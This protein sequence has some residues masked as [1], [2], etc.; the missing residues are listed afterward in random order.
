MQRKYYFKCTDC[1]AEFHDADFMYLCP[2]CAAKNQPGQP[3]RG[4]LKTLYDFEE[5]K[6]RFQ[7]DHSFFTSQQ[8]LPLLPIE[9][10]ESLGH[11]AVGNTP[12]I[13]VNEL[14]GK[15]LPFNLALKDDSRN[16]T[17]SFKDRASVLVSAYAKEHG[18]DTII[19]AST[20][21][22]GSSL[23]GI[24]ASQKQKAIICVP[25]A[26][27]KAKLTQILMYGAQI[28]PVA[29]TYDDAF[30]L[31]VALTEKTGIFNRNTA[32]N[33]FT[34]EG[35][36]TVSFELFI[37]YGNKVPDKVFVPVGDG[38]IISGVYKGFEDLLELGLIDHMPV[39]VAVQA[40]GSNNIVN[41]LH[42]EKFVSQPSNTIADSI[43]VDIPRNFRMARKFLKEYNGE[44]VEVSDSK[45][46]DASKS[47]SS[48]TGVFAEP[49]AATAFAG[50]LKQIN[51]GKISA[52]ENVCVLLTGSGLK[53]VNA[54]QSVINIPDAVNPEKFLEDFNYKS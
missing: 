6:N 44:T 40:E 24:C 47:L 34:I 35:K 7:K 4:V 38:V 32:Y 52:A 50:L 11:L 18:I 42:A 46:L 33:P 49:A 2:F 36:K 1:G 27:P 3:P 8:W 25:A 17:F 54:V 26:A 53:D 14:N 10:A 28:V 20:G 22:A 41:N 39:I 51:E 43:S 5:L 29:G 45:I 21:N 37:Q 19:A 16:P 15:K 13:P 48:N 23:A 12:L 30:D 31:S 9:K